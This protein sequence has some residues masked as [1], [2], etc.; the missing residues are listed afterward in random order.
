MPAT[1]K[2]D[3]ASRITRLEPA[4][5]KAL[6]KIQFSSGT[7]LVIECEL[8]CPSCRSPLHP[9]SVTVHKSLSA[10]SS[11]SS[12]AMIFDSSRTTVWYDLGVRYNV[13]DSRCAG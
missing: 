7:K 3:L 9:S 11:G 2:L 6:A 13:R 4:F 1:V 5:V 10:P 8:L 12:A